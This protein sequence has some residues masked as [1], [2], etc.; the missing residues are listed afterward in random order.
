MGLIRDRMAQAMQIRGYSPRTIK[1]YLWCIRNLAGYF[2]KSPEL[3]T[4]EDINRFQHHLGEDKKLG[5]ETFN[6]H[7]AAMR[8]LYGQVLERDW[9]IQRI[10]LKKRRKKL[11][12]VMTL[13]E[14]GCLLS[15]TVSLRDRAML[16]TI[17]SGGLRLSEARGLRNLDIE[18]S[19]NVIRIE[20]GKGGKD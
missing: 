4:L 8:F 6:Q 16:S 12:R 19:R 7:V 20:K 13:E 10:P 3:L 2:R 9:D 17:Y 1:V 18:S 14:V 11:P 15:S 5:F